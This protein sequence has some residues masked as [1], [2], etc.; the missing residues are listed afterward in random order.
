MEGVCGGGGVGVGVGV[1]G[2]EQQQQLR[3]FEKGSFVEVGCDEEGFKGALYVATIIDTPSRSASKKKNPNHDKFY[4]EYQSLLEDDGSTLLREHVQAHLVRPLPP[5]LDSPSFELY[6]VVDAFYRDGWWTGDVTRVLDNSRFVVTFQNPPD[7]IVFGLSKL[8]FHQE[9]VNGKWV[10]LE[11]ERSRGLMFRAGRRVEILLGKEY[12]HDVW[13]PATVLRDLGNNTFLVEYQN[14]ANGNEAGLLKATV[15][16]Q[17]IRP[18]PPHLK[19]RN[20]TLLEKVDAFYKFGWWSGVITKELA[21]RRYIVYFKP[22]NKEMELN[23]SELRPHMEW[24][25]GKWVAASQDISIPHDYEEHVNNTQL[26]VQLA[27][28]GT[29][30]DNPQETTPSSLISRE[31]QTEQSTPCSGMPFPSDIVSPSN[32]V[33]QENPK[34]EASLSRPS[35]KLREGK[36]QEKRFLSSGQS[37]TTP[38]QT[39]GKEKLPGFCSTTITGADTSCLEQSM[40]GCLP[41]SKTQSHSQGKNDMMNKQHEVSNSDHHVTR[42]VRRRGRPSKS[43]V[44]SPEPSVEG[45]KGGAA[46]EAA[47]DPGGKES[48]ERQV[49][50][51]VI[52]ALACN[53]TRSPPAKKTNLFPCEESLKSIR[54]EKAQLNDPS[55]DKVKETILLKVGEN[56]PKRKRGRPRKFLGGDLDPSDKKQ[57]VDV[58]AADEMVAKD[59]IG[60]PTVTG[61]RSKRLSNVP[62]KHKDMLS[63]MVKKAPAKKVKLTNEKVMQASSNEQVEKP[64]SKRGSRQSIQHQHQIHGV[65]MT[66]K[67]PQD[68]SGLKRDEVLKASNTMKE[69]GRITDEVPSNVSDDQPLSMWLE[70]MHLPTTFDASGVSLHG[71]VPQ[72]TKTS[73]KQMDLVMQAAVGDSKEGVVFDP[74]EGLPFVKTFPLWETIESMEIFKAMPQKP[75]FHPLDSCKESSRE[76]LAIGCMVTFS[77]VVKKTSELQFNDPR[78]QIEDNLETLVDLEGHGFDVK[79]VR[80]RLTRLLLMKDRQELHQDHSKEL[81][82][83]IME[84][85]QEKTK[86]DEEIDEIDKLIRELDGKRA[87]AMSKKQTKDSEIAS[88]QL[89]ATAIDKS[90]KRIRLDFEKLAAAPW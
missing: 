87:F 73:E 50:I 47:E 40:D 46:V 5:L 78:S 84:C 80:D 75:H 59:E 26:A 74:N 49:S 9:W 32:S 79:M 6:D 42:A 53:Q 62:A 41:Y 4:V 35:R 18:R 58:V 48:V 21:D 55:R 86:I 64:P 14:I 66:H 30:E 34:C 61:A 52:I 37:D 70:G 60:H 51:P 19:D 83:R 25:D 33:E 24:I 22:I 2:A 12:Y 23:Q 67:N 28:P 10:R 16:L 82:S 76:G 54:E 36:V 11:K 69:I 31:R 71:M 13:F 45:K 90:M 56:G 43:Q 63:S 38:I 89:S 77:S 65:K 3:L 68:A 8:R 44:K 39:Q 1:G 72:C 57:N 17:H 7:E 29:R 81:E 88:L 85:H 15:D 20:F 27:S